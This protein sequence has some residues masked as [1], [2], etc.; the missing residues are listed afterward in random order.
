VKQTNRPHDFIVLRFLRWFCPPGLY[1]GIEGDLVEQFE[2]EATTIGEANARRNLIRNALSFFRPSI[3]LRNRFSFQLIN[4]MMFNSYI[5]ITFRNLLKN[6]GYSFINIAGLS[7]GI[8][9][10]LLTYNFVLFEQSYDQSHPDVERIYRIN[11]TN[12]WDPA[13]GVFGSVGP[14]V[15][16]ALKSDFA[17]IEEVLRINTPGGYIV[18]YTEPNGNVLAFNEDNVLA[19][20]S[21]FFSF[22]NFKLREGSSKALYGKDKVVLSDKAAKRLFGDEPALGKIIQLGDEKISV[23]VTGVTEPQPENVHFHFDYLLSMYTN[24]NI[25]RFEWSWIWTQTVTYV[26]LRPDA[27]AQALSDKL[28]TFADR[29]APA[30][31]KKLNMDYDQFIKEKG[32]WFLY[33]Q[34]VRDIYLHSDKIGNRIGP[35]GDI[36][37]VYILSTVAFFILLIA[38][39][40][41]INLSTARGATRAKEV[42]VKKTLGLTRSSLITQFQVEHIIITILSVVFGLLLLEL[43]RGMIQPLTGISIPSA[44]DSPVFLV[45]IFLF[46]FVVGFLAGLYPSFYLTAFSPVQVL[47]GKASKGFKA[48]GLRNGLVVFQFT[49][50]I[51]LMAATL[52]V[53]QQLNFFRTQSVGFDKENLLII[54]HAEK[55]DAQLESFR[56]EITGL[57][58]VRSTSISMDIR[59][60]YEDIFMREGSDQKISLSQYKIDEHFMSTTG[61]QLASGRTY[62]TKRVSDK[63]AVL[64][65]ETAAKLMGWSNEEALGKKILYLGDDVGAQEVIGVVKDFHFQSLRQNISPILFMNVK[66]TMWGDERIVTVRYESEV[67]FELLAKLESKWNQLVKEATPFSY[68][69]YQEELKAQYQQE[70]RLGSLF[71]IFT[72]L[73]LVIAVIGLVGLVAYSAEVMKKELG[74]RKVFGAT[75]TRLVVMMN[76]QY[77]RLIGISLMISAPLAWWALQQW[78]DTFAYRININPMVFLVAGLVELAMA[79]TCVG[80]LS[81]RAAS[82]NPSQV[83]REE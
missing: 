53:F 23:E 73:S 46:P 51:A 58:G 5:R 40:N 71:S 60:G 64:I 13:G 56:N 8:A 63:D 81:L 70:E 30:T 75:T 57:P 79:M 31:F 44:W 67:P 39:V 14:A 48:S 9:V 82:I 52:I 66:S 61:L 20:D 50:S 69:F 74:I 1:E 18:R 55:L 34:P 49:I 32:G 17:E 76:S 19:A 11:Q 27:N 29:H 42:G 12:I 3:I 68:S 37:Y 38:V 77:V 15:A 45:S 78:L 62:D 2:Y 54:N 65:N 43:F 80:Y 47:K 6:K 26:K 10:C 7:L 41:F 59:N 72:G 16:S 33:I 24:P 25:K 22:F 36:K 83:L 21:N 28:I 35:V 4:T